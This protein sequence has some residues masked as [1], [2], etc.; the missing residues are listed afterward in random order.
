MSALVSIGIVA[1]H[2]RWERATRLAEHLDADVVAVDYD[3]K[4]GAGANH[5]VCYDWLSQAE[6]PWCLVLEDDAVPVRRFGQQLDAVLR[7]A[8][9]DHHLLSLYLGRWRPAHWQPRIAQVIAR[10][11]HYLRASELLHHVA[12]AIRTPL[13]PALLDYL[14]GNPRYQAGKLPIDEAVGAFARKAGMPI[15]YTHPSIVNHDPRLPTVIAR[16]VSQHPGETGERPPGERRQ[17]WA[18]GTRKDWQPS[19]AQIPEPA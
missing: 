16:H 5:E 14:R 19:I 6:T 13:I 17:A 12:V 18:F 9:P 10:D 11:E 8:P 1:H 15:L 4:L 7:A 2:R 3:G